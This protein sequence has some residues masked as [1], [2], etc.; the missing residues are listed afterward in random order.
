MKTHEK[1][2]KMRKDAKLS[3]RELAE[4]SGF[5][6]HTIVHYERGGNPPSNDYVKFCA[7]YFGYELSSIQD[8]AK[9]L[10]KMS[11]N[12]QVIGICR[13]IECSNFDRI[14][15]NGVIN[16]ADY[17]PSKY[18]EFIRLENTAKKLEKSKQ[19]S[20]QDLELL[21]LFSSLDAEVKHSLKALIKSIIAKGARQ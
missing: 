12:E 19:Y 17:T 5:S 9:E 4:I 15:K 16:Q 2:A 13:E 1:L 14:L 8:N 7:L 11:E 20:K 10:E 3:R 21:A 6:E 18:A